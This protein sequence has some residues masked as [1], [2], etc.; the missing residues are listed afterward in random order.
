VTALNNPRGATAGHNRRRSGRMHL[1]EDIR[2]KVVLRTSRW[3]L[4]V[5]CDAIPSVAAL[6]AAARSAI[7]AQVEI[8]KSSPLER[9]LK[10]ASDAARGVRTYEVGGGWPQGVVGGE[11]MGI[12]RWED[13]D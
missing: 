2:T 5:R 13:V 10:V 9:T 4:A 11:E 8:G 12:E 7:G 3:S 6:L 1:T